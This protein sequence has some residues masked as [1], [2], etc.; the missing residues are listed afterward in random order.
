MDADTLIMHIACARRCATRFR[1]TYH[2]IKDGESLRMVET[3][4]ASD[5]VVVRDI[6]SPRNTQKLISTECEAK[7]EIDLAM[8]YLRRAAEII[9]MK[10]SIELE[11][12]E[13]GAD[14]IEHMFAIEAFED[15]QNGVPVNAKKRG[16]FSRMF[17]RVPY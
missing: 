9:R 13:L 14:M 8:P 2:L 15:R 17:G 7:R 5:I 1:T 10:H 11:V 6:K 12:E 16:I 4:A 3:I